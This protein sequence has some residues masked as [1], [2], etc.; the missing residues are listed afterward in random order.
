[1][2]TH[3]YPA[4]H[5]WR[6]LEFSMEY[7]EEKRCIIKAPV[8]PGLCGDQGTM[9]VGF[10]ATLFDLV[11]GELAARTAYP[12]WIATADLV[13]Y[14]KERARAGAA[15]F[16]AVARVVRAGRS[17]IV[18]ES[19]MLVRSSPRGA[20]VSVG[21]AMAAF[22]RLKS[23]EDTAQV[24]RVDGPHQVF[25][26][27]GHV[28][29]QSILERAGLRVLDEAAGVVEIRMSEY[30]RNAFHGVNGGIFGVLADAA[31]QCA[32]RAAA[33]RPLVT[34]D[35]AI[36]YLSM[37]KA[38]PFRTRATVVRAARDSVLT[39]IEIVD[40]GKDGLLMAVAMNTAT[41]A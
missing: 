34:S 27:E 14:S 9:Q 4:D 8:A 7:D 29:S 10:I 41:A 40:A 6:D 30:I 5:M 16:T 24:A 1:M 13:L 28:P 17:S 18:I 11:G 20:A 32:A 38:G 12:D 31:G 36:H 21:A 26:L 37:G 22:T 23:R 2:K 25:S 33:G 19:D 39:R 3:P 35:L 15:E